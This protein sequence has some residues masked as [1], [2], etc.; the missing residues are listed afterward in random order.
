MGMGSGAKARGGMEVGSSG[1]R[2]WEEVL[3]E[4]NV[5]RKKWFI[6]MA[7]SFHESV[8]VHEGPDP[9]IKLYLYLLRNLGEQR[10]RCWRVSY[11]R[12]SV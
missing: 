8:L 6:S 3:W 4:E 11:D 7:K 2:S 9:L 1:S 5:L 12:A 10:A